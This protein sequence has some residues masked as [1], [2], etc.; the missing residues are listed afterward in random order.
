[1]FVG[2]SLRIRNGITFLWLSCAWRH[3]HTLKK[4]STAALVV[5]W[6]HNHPFT[7]LI[8]IS[9]S[10]AVSLL[11]QTLTITHCWQAWSSQAVV[12]IL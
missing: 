6:F 9:L 10:D 8:W 5:E 11:Q 4:L 3:T 7:Y 1:M 12:N 2:L